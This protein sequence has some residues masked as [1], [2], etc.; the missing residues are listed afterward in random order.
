MLELNSISGVCPQR[1]FFNS[2]LY[3][4]GD[5]EVIMG[6]GATDV[7]SGSRWTLGGLIPGPVGIWGGVGLGP[8]RSWSF[9]D[10]F[11]P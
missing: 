2:S 9:L 3:W 6:L 7:E 1:K 5:Q 10:V 11:A 8:E 4:F